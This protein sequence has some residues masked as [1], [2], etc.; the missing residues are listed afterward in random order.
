MA[1]FTTIAAFK[2][3]VQAFAQ[4]LDRTEKRK[5]ARLMAEKGQQ[6]AEQVAS[7]DLGGDPKFSGWAPRLDTRVRPSSND[8]YILTP[9]RAS[10]GPWTVAQRGRNAD[11]G[12]GRFQGPSVNMRTGRTRRR[13]DG[14]V[15]SGRARSGVRYNG[16]TR[17]KNTADKAVARMEQS[18]Q[19]IAERGMKDALRRHFDV[20]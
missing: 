18:A 13:S 11:G 4:E 1:D 12:V 20:N 7:G 17:G 2:S 3:E 10:A 16:R 14:T 8:G 6:V 9:T 5:I 19:P 15:G